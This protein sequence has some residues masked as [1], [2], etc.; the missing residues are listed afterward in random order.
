M[1]VK[2]LLEILRCRS[3][4]GQVMKV[5]GGWCSQISRKSANESCQ[6]YVPAASPP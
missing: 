5:P 6:A 4:P 3:N 1:D 2:E